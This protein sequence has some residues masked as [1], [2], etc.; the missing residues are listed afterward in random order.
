MNIEN[1]ISFKSHFCVGDWTVD[2]A[3][4]LI[5]LGEQVVN[6]EPKVMDVL[7]YLAERQGQV[8]SREELEDNVW[9]GRIVSY[10]ALTS[11]IVKLRKAL[12]ST[13]E[14]P[15]IKTIP[16]RGYSLVAAV[17]AVTAADTNEA[18]PDENQLKEI[19]QDSY[20]PAANPPS[21]PERRQVSVLSC[22]L[23]NA[24]SIYKHMDPEDVH[25][26]LQQLQHSCSDVVNHYGGHIGQYANGEMVIYYGYPEAHEGDAERAVRT[27]LGLVDTVKHMAEK[28]PAIKQH[29]S[30]R[31]GIH[32]GLVVVGE[33]TS[34]NAQ[35]RLSMV[36]DTPAMADGLKRL[37]QVDTVV[38]SESTKRLVEKLFIFDLLQSTISSEL[39]SQKVYRVQAMLYAPSRSETMLTD[40][41]TPLVG[42]DVEIDLLMQRWVQS[43]YGDS[44]V[45]M[46][47]AESGIGKSRILQGL[48]ERLQ[49]EDVERILYFCSPYHTNSSLYPVTVQLQRTLDIQLNDDTKNSLDKLESY[50]NEL[51]LVV[52]ETAPVFAELLSLP[53]AEHYPDFRLRAEE[54]KKLT[55]ESLLQMFH[56]LAQRKPVLLILED[57]HWIDPTT[58]ELFDLLINELRSQPVFFVNSYRPEFDPPWSAYMQATLLRLNRLS[59]QESIGIIENVTAGRAL[60]EKILDLIIARTDGVPLFVEEL[61]RSILSS[62]ALQDSG[63]GLQLTGSLQTINIPES[64]QD[65]LMARL[66]KLKH[67]KHIAQIAAIIGRSFSHDLL[68]AVVREEEMYINH[69]LTELV[70]EELLFRRGVQ[71][72]ITYEFKHALVQ[73]AAYQ[74]LLKSKRQ[75]YHRR[76]AEVLEQLFPHIVKAQPEVL[77]YHYTEAQQPQQAIN[78]WLRAGKRASEHSANIEAITQLNKGLDLLKQ[79]P[80]G[81]INT[82][83]RNQ[84]ELLLLLALG[85]ALL[86]A[87][88]LGSSEAESVYLRARELCRE[89]DANDALFTVTWGLWLLCQ[90]RGRI[91][92]AQVL[93][94]EL[95]ALADKLKQPAYDLEAHHAAWTTNF[96]LSHFESTKIHSQTGIK[97]YD[98]KQHSNH[99]S[100]FGGHDPGCCALYNAAMTSWLLGYP[101]QAQARAEQSVHLAKQIN[102]LMTQALA[103]VFAGFIA[104]WCK[105]T[106]RVIK[107]AQFVIA[108]CNR[109]RIAPD[110]K[111]QALAL[112]SWSDT[113]S[114]DKH[115]GDIAKGIAGIEEAIKALRLTGVRTHESYLLSLLA[116]AY[117]RTHQAEQGL[118][119]INDALS[120]VEQTGERTFETEVYRLKGEMLLLQSSNN[121]D[122]AIEN[123]EKAIRLAQQQQSKSMELRAV[124]S[125]VRAQQTHKYKPDLEKLSELLNWFTE[126]KDL[127]DQKDAG[128]LV[129]LLG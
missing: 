76:I 83:Q 36:G 15:V 86:S 100:R 9:A 116:D 25:E 129:A 102:H 34:G 75:Q 55:L 69:A 30:L 89:A 103:N 5:Q 96:R 121:Y 119:T 54:I 95:L 106:K 109:H 43:K 115:G 8:V 19:T 82:T 59:K 101:E 70:D 99:A 4:N 71:P 17:T 31:M 46:L 74:S 88:G 91:K 6:L 26:L 80:D 77:A 28:L 128:E 53:T 20:I 118:R 10:D 108:L 32:T 47:C 35:E 11:S 87:K 2:P 67:A 12:N 122:A 18:N 64:L 21:D 52:S 29:L 93:S 33:N 97:L 120:I 78:Y 105:D 84:L 98:I 125:L 117:L 107:H 39:P 85:P 14:N 124:T 40:T 123:L 38:I 41:L 27:A 126:G 68:V 13:K 42:R 94:R 104:Q 56:A 22:E 90:K 49:D 111:A 61:T 1:N 24:A 73:D 110:C 16:K 127:P 66:D 58:R 37:A 51:G 48:Q 45:V 50:L 113:V 63:D 7:V 114:Q 60:P 72:D 81:E 3:K 23:L 92:E 79:A 112:A 57:A 65:S 44:Q 62:G